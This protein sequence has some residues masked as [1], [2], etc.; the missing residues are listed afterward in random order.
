MRAVFGLVLLIGMGLA[1][2]A[3]FMVKGYF[4]AQ[5]VQLAQEQRRSANAIATVDLYAPKRDLTYGELL[6][7]DDVQLIKYAKEFLPK[8]AFQTQEELFPAGVETPRVVILPMSINE[9]ILMT[10]VTEP[11]ASR[12]LTAL[13]E[14][15]MRAFPIEGR[16]AT[17]FGVLRPNDRI[18]VYWTGR[19]TNGNEVTNLLKSGLE[20]IAVTGDQEFA[21][22]P[23][24]VV[25][26][27]TPEEVALLTQATNSGALTLSLVGA[28]D[29]TN[30]APIQ[31]DNQRITGE[32]AEVVAPA[33]VIEAEPER[34]YQT[35]RRG[36]ATEET[37]VDCS[38]Q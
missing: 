23:Q 32:V 9:P 6:T 11:G 28:G 15:G 35:V 7:V 26:Q 19:L 8:G 10:K 3:V 25:V 13:V 5:A 4:D 2:F 34:C 21:G 17:G 24:S 37:E 18:D 30:A 38:T 12:G 22:G 36:T 29:L 16:V 31:I 27:V 20:I 33:P 14:P 1:G